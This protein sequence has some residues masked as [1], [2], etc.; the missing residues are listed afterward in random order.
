MLSVEYIINNNILF[1]GGY[2]ES[3]CDEQLIISLEFQQT[4]K[5][6]SLKIHGPADKGPRTGTLLSDLI[7]SKMLE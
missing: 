7:K 5:L 4:V 1:Q 6:H 3:D 2:L